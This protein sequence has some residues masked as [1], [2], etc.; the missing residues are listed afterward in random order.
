M[1]RT[2]FSSR[3]P[4]THP[5]KGKLTYFPE[6]IWAHL[7]L[8]RGYTEMQSAQW[9]HEYRGKVLSE[10]ERGL[11]FQAIASAILDKTPKIH[12][13]RK[14]E[15][16]KVGDKFEPY[17]WTGLPYRTPQIVFA[18]TLEVLQLEHFQTQ[19]EGAKKTRYFS[20][21]GHFMSHWELVELAQNDGLFID[22]FKDWF[23]KSD[24]IQG[25]IIYF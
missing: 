7:I 3:F 9:L 14:G 5:R 10:W 1:K 8:N 20:V 25:Q 13:I 6:K 2:P 21:E 23:S 24:E 22:D 18:P 11:S 19:I 16:R 12:T 17:V 4:A 15:K